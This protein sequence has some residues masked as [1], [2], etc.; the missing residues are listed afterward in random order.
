MSESIIRTNLNVEGLFKS[1]KDGILKVGVDNS[2]FG[3][4]QYYLYLTNHTDDM[5]DY[6][7]TVFLGS[8]PGSDYTKELIHGL[9]TGKLTNDSIDYVLNLINEN[10]GF[11]GL[12][13]EDLS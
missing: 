8:I 4:T 11:V 3:E 10:P 12:L 7:K 1:L 13:Q 5:Y 9:Y 2:V 6:S